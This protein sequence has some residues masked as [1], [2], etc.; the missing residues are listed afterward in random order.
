MELTH[1]SEESSVG[2]SD[3]C[4]RIQVAV[5]E[6]GLFI[7]CV[8]SSSTVKRP[9]KANKYNKKKNKRAKTKKQTRKKSQN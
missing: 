2:F 8:V 5:D 7:D 1:A 6:G 9:N 3:G 4:S